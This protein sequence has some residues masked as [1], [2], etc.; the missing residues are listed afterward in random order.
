MPPLQVYALV[1]FVQQGIPPLVNR[2]TDLINYKRIADSSVGQ[3]LKM[4]EEVI[5]LYILVSSYGMRV[6]I[7]LE[8]KGIESE[9]QE[10]NMIDNSPLLLHM[11]PV[12]KMA[13]VLIHNGK[14]IRKVSGSDFVDKKIYDSGKGILMTR[15]EVQEGAKEMIGCLKILGGASR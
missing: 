2:R 14:P 1:S 4:A 8:E 7:A 3:A 9:Y 13:P 10:K 15:G 11:N 5:L 12:H 6:R